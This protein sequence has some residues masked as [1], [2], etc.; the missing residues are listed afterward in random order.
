MDVWSLWN[1]LN[2]GVII[3]FFF[4]CLSIV[5]HLVDFLLNNFRFV[6]CW[7]SLEL[8]LIYA[9]VIAED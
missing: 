9:I 6:L 5:G 3:T 1:L 2:L 4:V 7:N 8:N